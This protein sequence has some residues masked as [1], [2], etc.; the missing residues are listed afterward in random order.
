M[1]GAVTNTD[2]FPDRRDAL[3]DELRLLRAAV[4]A[5][6][7]PFCIFDER[8]RLIV[9][10]AAYRCNHEGAFL[11]YRDKLNA[12]CLTY[13]DLLRF[14]LAGTVAADELEGVVARRLQE[15][16]EVQGERSIRR[17]T[18]MGYLE[19]VQYEL[20][21]G[22][23]AGIALDINDLI[24]SNSQL[25]SVRHHAEQSHAELEKARQ[26]IEKIA[27]Y[28]ELTG[29]PNRHL[30]RKTFEEWRNDDDR[31]DEQCVVL[32]VDLDRFKRVNDNLGHAAGDFVLKSVAA[33]LQDVCHEGDL[34]VRLGGDEFV[35]LVIGNLE[36]GRG[37]RIAEEIVQR[38]SQPILFNDTPCRIGASVGMTQFAVAELE[39]DDVLDQSDEAMYRAKEEG[40]GCVVSFDK[41]LRND[42]QRRKSVVDNL[43]AAVTEQQFFA[44]YQG[45]Y[46]CADMSLMGAEVL[47]RWSLPSGEVLT[48]KV[49]FQTA[50]ALS[51][52]GEIDRC[53]YQCVLQ[54]VE[55]FASHGI[56]LP[57]LSFNVSYERLFDKRLADDL[58][59]LSSHVNVAIELHDMPLTPHSLQEHAALFDTLK[60][61]GVAI[62]IDNFGVDP[63]SLEG[64]LL[65][66]PSAVKL[67]QQIV[68]RAVESGKDRQLIRSIVNIGNSTGIAVVA[69]GVQSRDQLELMCELGCS[70]VQGYALAEPMSAQSWLACHSV[71][72][73]GS[74]VA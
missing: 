29:L 16:S 63:V 1:L 71:A 62:E 5:L 44:V 41:R 18:K 17:F 42:I 61:L 3:Q 23:L 36:G 6:P 66:S 31:G 28:D 15:R 67:D 53:V 4:S 20:E 57:R 38:V 7:F 32:H 2:E 55:A 65:L 74:R 22:G 69:E 30:L 48:P 60:G 24:A 59:Y 68:R 43:R 54:D 47:C 25:D 49:F 12:R 11:H 56:G 39:L 10:N 45:Q 40:R 34:A 35:V 27:Y 33:V 58:V 64:L 8:D 72:Q 50:S 21:G 9:W 52:M 46:R 51:L 70:S 14:E 13:A 73:F 26:T 19:I 37:H